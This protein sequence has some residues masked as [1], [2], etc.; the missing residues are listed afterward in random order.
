VPFAKRSFVREPAPQ[1]PA[2]VSRATPK[3]QTRLYINV[4]EAMGIK[5][6]DV[7][8]AIHGQTGLPLGTVGV[9]DIRDRHLFVNV[10]SEHAPAIISKL[11]RAR[12]KGNSVKVKFA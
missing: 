12:I 6:N 9:V 10:A 11:N 2:K 5:S 1:R 8:D 7:V 4:G 3:E